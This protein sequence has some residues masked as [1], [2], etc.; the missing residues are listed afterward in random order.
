M[1]A[2]REAGCA[3]FNKLWGLLGLAGDEWWFG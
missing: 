1:R 3:W 2:I